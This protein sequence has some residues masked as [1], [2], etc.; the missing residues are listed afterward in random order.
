MSNRTTATSIVLVALAAVACTGGGGSAAG[1]AT[2][3]PT[4][5]P[6]PSIDGLSH[7]TGPDEIVLRLDESGGF[8]PPEFLA[9]HVP[10]FTLYGDGTVVFV[11][12]TA[13]VPPRE[14][15]IMTGQPVRTA[16]LTEEQ[17]QSLL[18]LAIR[19]GGLGS[20]RAEYQNPLVADAATAVFTLNA[21]GA[22]KTVSVVALGMEDQEV[23]A[24][25]AI[26]K[27][28]AGLGNRLRDFDAGGTLQSAPYEAAAYRGVLQEQQGLQGVAI[29]DW[30]WT[31]LSPADFSMPSDHNV[32][33]QGTATL[34]PDQAAALGIDGFE[35]G[36]ASGVFLRDDA[37]KTYS[38]VLR[39]L[40]PDEDA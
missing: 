13:S 29:R 37:G 1:G 16:K 28:L 27:A 30:P 38:F 24:D 22:A 32:L 36:I 18:E 40:L 8:V 39:P 35:S 33:P 20:A 23:N 4:T 11:Q 19:D 31:D 21:D 7:P 6:S 14:D 26:K 17:V 34:T 9:A 2:P 5:A 10:Q 3:A 15:G 12:S 25:T